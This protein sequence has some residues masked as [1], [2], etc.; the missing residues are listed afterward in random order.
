MKTRHFYCTEQNILVNVKLAATAAAEHTK[1][2]CDASQ[3]T[4]DEYTH[5][6]I[7]VCY[8]LLKRERER[9]RERKWVRKQ[10]VFR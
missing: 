1:A 7:R 6:E 2:W 10:V 8:K 3:K 9:E 4:V 5:N